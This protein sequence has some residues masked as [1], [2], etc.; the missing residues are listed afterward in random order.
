M[1][2][3][4]GLGDVVE[5]DIPV[6]D[7]SFEGLCAIRHANGN[8]YWILINQDTTGIGVYS[9]T[10]QG[11][12]LSS[13]YET[14]T[15]LTGTIKASPISGNPEPLFYAVYSKVVTSSGLLLDFD[16]TT[17]VLS[18]PEQLPAAGS[19][20]VE[21]SHNSQYLYATSSGFGTGTQQLVRYNLASAIEQ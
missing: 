13:V 20:A 8:D 21:F 19:E 12:T 4:N 11:I 10:S 7:Y 6:H 9:V 16:L 17:G 14:D 15:P 18:N 2:L 1:S 5:A 3:N